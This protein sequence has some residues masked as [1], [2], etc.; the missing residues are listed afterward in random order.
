MNPIFLGAGTICL[1]TSLLL[2]ELTVGHTYPL[3]LSDVDGNSLSTADGHFIVLVLS[4][5]ANSDKAAAVGARIPDFCL[6]NPNYRMITVVSFE[7][8]HSSPI[9][10]VLRA[11]IR[12]RLDS[13]AQRLQRRY[14]EHKITRDARHDVFAVADFDGAVLDQLKLKPEAGAF[15][16]LVFGKNGELLKDWADIPSADELA[17]TLK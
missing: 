10:A 3:R 7:T 17:A 16:V 6:G 4:N 13:E 12:H 8:K 5:K 11:A 1:S 2:A 14:E 9:R 15:R